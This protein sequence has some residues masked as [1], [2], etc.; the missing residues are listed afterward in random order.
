MNSTYNSIEKAFYSDGFKL[1][2]KALDSENQEEAIYNV[3]AEMYKTIDNLIDSLTVFAQQQSHAIDCKKG[4]F[5]CCHQPVFALDYELDFLK[6]YITEKFPKE[7]QVIVQERAKE[8]TRKLDGLKEDDLLNSKHPCPLIE[9]GSCSAYEARP[10]ACRIYLSTN[11]ISCLKFFENPEDKNNY[12][13]LLELPMRAGR[14]MNEGFKSALKTKGY[15][16]EEYR[17]EEKL[18]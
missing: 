8:K 3:I 13:N 6:K 11:L 9:D 16:T 10:M 1:G 4:C 7:K 14:L 2:M 18:S 17:I 15:K 12:P 5:W